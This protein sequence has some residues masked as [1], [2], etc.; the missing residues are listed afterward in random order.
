MK[1]SR[2]FLL[3]A[4]A[5]AVGCGSAGAISRY[6]STG[7]TC[8][9]ARDRVAQE[10]AVIFRYPSKRTSGLRLYDRFVHNGSYCATGEEAAPKAVPTRSGEC[11]LLSCQQLIDERH[12]GTFR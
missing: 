6:E 11:V 2:T 5:M 12:F 8:Q 10:G 1:R 3:A 7:M 9:A 4:L